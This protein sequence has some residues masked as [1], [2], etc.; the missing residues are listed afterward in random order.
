MPTNLA[1]V[2]FVEYILDMV[3]C[4]TDVCFPPARWR[5]INQPLALGHFTSQP[6]ADRDDFATESKKLTCVVCR[7]SYGGGQ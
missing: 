5:S 7:Q 4:E 6:E 1:L 3:S 2:K